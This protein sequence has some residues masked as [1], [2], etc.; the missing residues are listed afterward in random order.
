[1]RLFSD[2]K[3]TALSISSLDNLLARSVIS[4]AL[5]AFLSVSTLCPPVQAEVVRDRDAQV[6]GCPHSHVN[7]WQDPDVEP[8]GVVIALHGLIMHGGVF[9][10]LANTLAEKGYIVV[11]ADMRG[12]GR[13]APDKVEQILSKKCDEETSDLGVKVPVF[14]RQAD[15]V[16]V[17]VEGD[18]E[19]N[20]DFLKEHSKV[21]YKKSFQDLVKLTRAVKANHPDLPLFLVGESMG[22]GMAIHI[23]GVTPESLDGIVLSSPAIKKKVNLVPRILVDAA[24]F[25]R[26]PHK[27][28]DLKPYI[29]KFASEDPV[30]A[31][32]CA[33]DPLVRKSL[34]PGEL[35]KT[36]REIGR[37]IKYAEMVPPSV[38]VLIIQGDRDRMV[39]SNGVVSLLHR[40]KSEDQTVK[41]F[42][43]KG[44]LLLETPYITDE[45]MGTVTGWLNQKVREGRSKAVTQSL[46]DNN[47]DK[48]MH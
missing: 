43:G 34:R 20:D 41:W 26:H 39:K 11:A 27:P 30:I 32:A 33:Q 46:P 2:F 22:A 29:L 21:V 44:H 8:R 40:L 31:R 14:S 18:L 15:L 3:A 17:A 36:S 19:E 38:P 4:M 10:S 12:Y 6:E 28:V 23:A 7:L 37:N 16:D 13:W 5:C 1:M 48:V 9:D 25:V 47:S 42:P 24:R 35:L 45:T